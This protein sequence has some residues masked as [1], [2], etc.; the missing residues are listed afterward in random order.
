MSTPLQSLPALCQYHTTTPRRHRH[1][2][3]SIHGRRRLHRLTV[4]GNGRVN[5]KLQSP[6]IQKGAV[7]MVY[8]PGAEASRA[9]G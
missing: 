2:H 5:Y 9:K 7:L 6:C 4:Q 8:T 3:Q 1:D